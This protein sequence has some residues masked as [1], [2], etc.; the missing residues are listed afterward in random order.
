ML[1]IIIALFIF[2]KRENHRL[3][4]YGLKESIFDRDKDLFL[5]GRSAY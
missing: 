5:S 3:V 1:N 4:D 2:F